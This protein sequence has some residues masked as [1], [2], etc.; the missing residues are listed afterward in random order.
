MSDTFSVLAGVLVERFD[1]P[2]IRIKP[3]SAIEAD[4][5][6]DSLDRMDLLLAI[7]ERYDMDVNGD[8]VETLYTI[9][10]LVAFID[11]EKHLR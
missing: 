5:G 2:L 11:Y 1:V 9:G 3:S 10:D 7:E 8:A 6:L 4:L